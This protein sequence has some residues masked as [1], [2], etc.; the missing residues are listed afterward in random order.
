MIIALPMN[1]GKTNYFVNHAY[2]NYL[3]NAGF[4]PLS[5]F[6]QDVNVDEVVDMCSGLLLPGG[7]DIDPVYYDEDNIDSYAVDPEKDMLERNLLYAFT[8]AGKPVFG[9]CRGFQLIARELMLE[10]PTNSE[11]NSFMFAQ[12]LKGHQSNDNVNVARHVKTH[13]IVT[14]KHS[15]YG[16]GDPNRFSRMYVNSM[17]HQGLVVPESKVMLTVKEQ[18]KNRI[19]IYST[20]GPIE[21]RGF[22]DF[23]FNRNLSKTEKR[24]LIVEA[25]D[26]EFRNSVVRGVQWH[27]EELND[28]QL[29][30]NYFNTNLEQAHA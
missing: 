23:G 3:H 29:L 8:E 16:E 1:N 30:Q 5:V 7:I 6:N 13:N 20:F 22:T 27:P 4:T 25:M 11:L 15:L 24:M 19:E 18:G 10:Y 12:H 21:I 14:N 26:V 9:I 17:H 28:V 2:V